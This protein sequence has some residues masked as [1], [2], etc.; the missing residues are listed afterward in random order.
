MHIKT[1]KERGRSRYVADGSL[2][3]YCEYKENNDT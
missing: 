3:E 2:N 1:E